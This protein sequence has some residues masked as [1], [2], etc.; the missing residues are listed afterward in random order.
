MKFFLAAVL[1]VAAVSAH[2]AELKTKNTCGKFFAFISI[3]PKRN[4][5]TG[6]P[7]EIFFRSPGRTNV[8]AYNFS[9]LLLELLNDEPHITNPTLQTP[10]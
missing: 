10:H 6:P 8:L 2:K 5:S 9:I 4:V 1:L 3:R 7:G